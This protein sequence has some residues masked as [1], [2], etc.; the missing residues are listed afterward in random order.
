MYSKGIE[1]EFSEECFFSDV[2]SLKYLQKNS[3]IEQKTQTHSSVLKFRFHLMLTGV[4][5]AS[6]RGCCLSCSQHIPSA[7]HF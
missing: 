5:A 6:G 4:P 7:L 1:T 2:S 3:F